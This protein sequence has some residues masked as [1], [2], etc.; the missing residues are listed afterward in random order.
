MPDR[1]AGR[2]TADRS[3]TKALVVRSNFSGSCK[4]HDI[5]ITIIGGPASGKSTLTD[6][7]TADDAGIQ[8]FGVRRFFAEQLTA[9][10]ELGDRVRAYVTSNAWIPDSIV[11]EGVVHELR[12]RLGRSFILE[13][14]P[15]NAHQARLLDA[16]LTDHGLP[17]DAAIHV[18][19]PRNVAIERAARRQV[20]LRC[21]GGSHQVVLN[22]TGS[23][24]GCGNP[25]S[26]RESDS[27]EAFLCRLD[28]HAGHAAELVEYYAQTG[29][30]INVPGVT[31]PSDM[32]RRC[33]AA[34]EAQK[35][36][37]QDITT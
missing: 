6:L 8:T 27:G 25:P 2:R 3:V 33:R 12:N 7:L 9:G 21:D 11:V 17:L 28:T 1:R 13:G 24:T 32:H 19:T 37:R 22:R 23:C 5:R 31:T 36:S 30:L 34:L 29:R 20:C 4:E 15:G 10:S 16:V 14:M 18:E 35:H 26:R